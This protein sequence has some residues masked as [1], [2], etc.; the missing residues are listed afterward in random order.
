MYPK[1]FKLSMLI[2][3]IPVTF[4]I[5]VVMFVWLMALSAAEKWVK[6]MKE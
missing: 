5:S 2:I 1:L 4:P 6:L 3:L